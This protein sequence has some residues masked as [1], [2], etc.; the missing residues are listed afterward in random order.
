M[1]ILSPKLISMRGR[2]FEPSA[3]HFFIEKTGALEYNGRGSG[4]F[5]EGAGQVFPWQGGHDDAG[6][7]QGDGVRKDL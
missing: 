4:T 3:P 5:S 7:S 6:D 2:R 1:Y